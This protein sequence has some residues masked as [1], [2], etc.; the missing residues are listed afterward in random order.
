MT[1]FKE[2]NEISKYNELE[3]KLE[4]MWHIKNN[5][6]FLSSSWLD[7]AREDL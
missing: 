6:I 7:F 3:I 1:R 4:K 5:S 2:Y